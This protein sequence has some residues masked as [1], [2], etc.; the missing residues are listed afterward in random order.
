M[1]KIDNKLKKLGILKA[2]DS[3][4]KYTSFKT[5]GPADFLIWPKDRAS[6]KE[7]II[8]S[9]EESIPVT[10]LGGCTNLL[11][12]D[13]GI[14][15]VV[16]MLNSMS[17]INGRIAPEGSGLIYSDAAVRK[18]EFL[19][20]CVEAGYEGMEFMAGIPGCI[21]GGIIMNAGTVD[22]NFVDILDSVICMSREGEFTARP[23]DRGTA[24]YRTMG[25]PD[26]YIVLGGLFKVRRTAD[27]EK[28]KTKID[29]ILCERRQKHPL[30]YP[31]AGSVF[32]NPAGHYSWKLIN[33]AGL[34][35]KRIG[36]ACVSEL[37]TNF[38][39][40]AG[41]AKSLDIVQ[42]IDHVKETVFL[43]F[44]INLEPEIKIIGE[45]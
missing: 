22:G 19:Q 11:V 38:I 43:K 23:V 28:I 26:D 17:K 45:F 1:K 2:N 37:H 13:K 14:R 41:K 40:N 21:G 4:K 39:I 5:G 8:I 27:S 29:T 10:I 3:L 7:I 16:I 44:N 25:I 36:D 6:M 35:G 18:D 31:S 12:G 42:L 33:D 34:K 24:G 20:Y 32:K 9:R 15:G 30:D